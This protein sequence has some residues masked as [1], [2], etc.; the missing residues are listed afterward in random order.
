[1]HLEFV[2][3]ASPDVPPAEVSFAPSVPPLN[4]LLE[5]DLP[6]FAGGSTGLAPFAFH[7]R[8]RTQ[9]ETLHPRTF[10]FYGTVAQGDRAA[11]VLDASGSMGHGRR[12]RDVPS[13]FQ[14]AAEELIRAIE[15][16]DPEQS[17]CVILFNDQCHPMFDAPQKATQLILANDANKNRLRRWLETVEPTGGTDPRQSLELAVSAGARSHISTDGR[18]ISRLFGTQAG[19]RTRVPRHQCDSDSHSH[20]RVQGAPHPT[21]THADGQKIRVALT[22]WYRRFPDVQELAPVEKPEEEP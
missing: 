19:N 10:G 1:M 4:D 15:G 2:E 20:N 6:L 3:V 13:R 9:E 12:N 8:Y 5:L 16:L 18:R 14:L 22:G 11:F 21:C 7:S 17:F